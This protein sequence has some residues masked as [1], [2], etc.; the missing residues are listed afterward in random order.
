METDVEVKPKEE[1]KSD[2]PAVC[3][4]CV[5][6]E[7]FGKNCYY[8]WVGKKHCTMWTADWEEAAMQQPL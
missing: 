1:K 6:W 8:Y 7:R 5:R 3:K 2:V 4:G